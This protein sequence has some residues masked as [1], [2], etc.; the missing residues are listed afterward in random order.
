MKIAFISHQNDFCFIP[1]GKCASWR[2]ATNK[3]QK[4]KIL[5]LLRAPSIW[6]WEYAFRKA[7]RLTWS[8]RRLVVLHCTQS[9]RHLYSHSQMMAKMTS[10]DACCASIGT[11]QRTWC[12]R[13]QYWFVVKFG[14]KKSII[15]GMN[16][17]PSENFSIKRS[18]LWTTNAV[19]QPVGAGEALVSTPEMEKFGKWKKIGLKIRKKRGKLV[20]IWKEGKNAPADR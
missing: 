15:T 13:D 18:N 1:L 8:C 7:L 19:T 17:V 9:Q 3:M 20:K 11:Q 2:R 6:I 10:F 12:W 4:I 5:K 16:C 14:L